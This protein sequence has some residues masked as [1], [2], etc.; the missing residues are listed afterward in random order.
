MRQENEAM[1]ELFINAWAQKYIRDQFPL[2]AIA[3]SQEIL[4]NEF[5]DTDR[6]DNVS[7]E[8]QADGSYDLFVAA[9][10]GNVGSGN[11]EFRYRVS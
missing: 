2:L 5:D 10:K 1:N 9:N 11:C 7:L 3:E 4:R 6:I 8:Q